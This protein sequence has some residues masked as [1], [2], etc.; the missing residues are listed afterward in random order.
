MN[1][2]KQSYQ[3]IKFAVLICI[4]FIA[5]F[6]YNLITPMLSDDLLYAQVVRTASS[7]GDLIAQEYDQYMNWTGRS[8]CHMLMRIFLS[9]DKAVFNVANSAAFVWLTLAIYLNVDGRKRYDGRL[10]VLINLL[11]WMFGVIFRQTVLWETGACN[12]LWGSMIIMSFVTLYRHAL[13]KEQNQKK[14]GVVF[15]AAVLLAGVLAGWCNENTSGGGLLL[16]VGF[17]AFYLLEERGRKLRP[18][19]VLGPAGQLGGLLL[20]VLAPGNAVRAAFQE[21]EH[22]GLFAYVSRFQKINLAICDEFLILLVI[23]A[24]LMS[25]AWHQNKEMTDDAKNGKNK[26]SDRKF[27]IFR[28]FGQNVAG[29]GFY[30]KTRNG[31]L[32][33]FVFIATCF[34]LIMAPEPMRRAYFGAGIFLTVAVAQ[35]FV[36]VA[37]EETVFASLKTSLVAVLALLMFFTY[38]ECGAHLMRVYREY[39]ERDAYLTQMAE[40][41]VSDVTIP[42]LRPDFDNKY[43]YGYESDIQ[44]DPGYWINVAYATYYG[45]DSVSGVLRE[46]WTEY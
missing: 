21:E 24:V 2:K 25:I 37:E 27:G 3:K 33:I 34:A 36:Y 39:N 15:S 42:M 23:L 9:M 44:E 11:L 40:A 32:W 26:E 22:S 28:R 45:F 12:Y 41:G 14:P 46:E 19:M 17:L 18:W 6:I 8:V 31:L 7:F 35:F 13:K 4:A 1:D 30:A 5:I 16:A 20:M 29:K 10:F 38:M 43:T